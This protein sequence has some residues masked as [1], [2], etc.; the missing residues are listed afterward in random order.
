MPKREKPGSQPPMLGL[1]WK[2]EVDFIDR[3]R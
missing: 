2:R 1:C 3:F